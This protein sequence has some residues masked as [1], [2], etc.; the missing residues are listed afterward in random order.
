[1]THHHSPARVQLV[2]AAPVRAAT[3]RRTNHVR[4]Q[5]DLVIASLLCRP[6]PVHPS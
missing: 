2:H 4:T 3:E 6:E 5:R 1:M